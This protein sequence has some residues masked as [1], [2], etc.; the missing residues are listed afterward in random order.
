[1]EFGVENELQ[2][3]EAAGAVLRAGCRREDA[4]E[5]NRVG[6]GL[7]LGLGGEREETAEKAQR[8]WESG[9]G[10]RRDEEKARERG[11]KERGES[12]KTRHDKKRQARMP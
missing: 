4:E 1:M 10:E 12:D 8:E 5:R 7:G 6:L 11:R 2:G 9:R 3:N